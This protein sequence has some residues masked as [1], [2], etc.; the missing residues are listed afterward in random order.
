MWE[1]CSPEGSWRDAMKIGFFWS[2]L[3]WTVFKC[4]FLLCDGLLSN[5][6]RII[7]RF[8]GRWSHRSTHDIPN[9]NELTNSVSESERARLELQHG[10]GVM[11]TPEFSTF[12]ERYWISILFGT[13]A[14]HFLYWHWIFLCMNKGQIV[15]NSR[16]FLYNRSAQQTWTKLRVELRNILLQ[17]VYEYW[18][19]QNNTDLMAG[20]SLMRIISLL[21]F[22][23][24]GRW[25][26]SLINC[27]LYESTS[28]NRSKVIESL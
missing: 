25:L 26:P 21:V 20:P 13:I 27:A 11:G 16:F 6:E 2:I 3:F 22:L 24:G 4:L 12:F 19:T 15:T 7:G 5:F 14:S 9:E 17:V 10:S 18:R 1:P 28:R 8:I 23:F